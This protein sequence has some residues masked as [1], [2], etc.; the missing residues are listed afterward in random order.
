MSETPL[1]SRTPFTKRPLMNRW[2]ASFP[3][4]GKQGPGRDDQQPTIVPDG[5]ANQATGGNSFGGIEIA[6]VVVGTETGKLP[7]TAKITD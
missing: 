2:I 4:I 3:T 1:P 5:T 6:A 7:D